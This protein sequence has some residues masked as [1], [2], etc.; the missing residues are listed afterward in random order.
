MQTQNFLF[1]EAE[2]KTTAEL[3]EQNN[4]GTFECAYCGE[5]FTDQNPCWNDEA[6]Y[7]NGSHKDGECKR[8]AAKG[9]RDSFIITPQHERGE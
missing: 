9:K 5:E 2:T 3:A 4:Y 7:A 1:D 6:T 8:C